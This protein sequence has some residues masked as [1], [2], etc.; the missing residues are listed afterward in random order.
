MKKK[1]KICGGNCINTKDGNYQ[2]ECCGNV[3]SEDSFEDKKSLAEK[4]SNIGVD[5]FEQNSSGVCEVFASTGSGS[6]YL[7]SPDGYAITNY[8]VVSSDDGIVSD[9]IRVKIVGKTVSAKIVYLAAYD[10]TMFCT[11]DD[12]AIIKLSQVPSNAKV[13]CFG[14]YSKVRTGETVFA[15]GNSLGKGTCIDKG[16]I[17]DRSRNGQILTDCI[18][19]PGNS[20]G[21]LFN[22]AG[23]VIGTI[24]SSEI[25]S[26]GSHAEGMHHAIPSNIVI[27]FIKKMGLV[28]LIN[29]R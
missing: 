19:N 22:I 13:L 1:C 28:P 8:H 15:I 20:G 5:I 27:N 24:V 11:N 9:E 23:E 12:L 16:I 7:I 4:E 17:S 6:G 18:V 29:K 21:P 10:K 3:F 25:R 26:D 14:D 2:C